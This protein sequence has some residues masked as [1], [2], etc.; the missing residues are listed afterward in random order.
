MR[1]AFPAAFAAAALVALPALA[2]LDLEDAQEEIAEMIAADYVGADTLPM[3]A[4]AVIGMLER[5]GYTDFEDFDVDSD[6]YEIEATSPEGIEV[7]IELDPLTGEIL[8][9]EED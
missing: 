2:D 4:T 3:S 8:E 6:E 5:L 9:I 7:E 1:T